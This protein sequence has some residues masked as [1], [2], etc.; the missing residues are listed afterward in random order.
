VI[1]IGLGDHDAESQRSKERKG[2][3][4]VAAGAIGARREASQRL[5]VAV[6]V[7][8]IPLQAA[9]VS[10]KACGDE[11]VGDAEGDCP[12]NAA[13][14]SCRD[15]SIDGMTSKHTQSSSFST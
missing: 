11:D 4:E 9:L 5:G 1:G 12:A 7:A 14:R 15:C 3:E 6:A 10:G 8:D 2:L 13:Q